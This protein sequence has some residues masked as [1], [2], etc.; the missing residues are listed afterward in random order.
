MTEDK[1]SPGELAGR[2]EAGRARPGA[3]RQVEP[4][5]FGETMNEKIDRNSP[6]R[7]AGLTIEDIPDD[8]AQMLDAEEECL[9]RTGDQSAESLHVAPPNVP[10]NPSIA[11]ESKIKV[12]P[13]AQYVTGEE[14]VDGTRMTRPRSSWGFTLVTLLRWV[15]M[16]PTSLVCGV[17]AFYL[18][19]IGNLLSMPSVGIPLEDFLARVFIELAS[20]AACFAVTIHLGCRI[21][22]SHK[23]CAACILA[24]VSLLIVGPAI[25][26]TFLQA[27]YWKLLRMTGGLL[28]VG[29]SLRSSFTRG[30]P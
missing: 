17:L 3:R 12:I 14:H 15:L 4:N 5:K 19:Q 10:A 20:G 24:G 11:P 16:I 2:S 29:I 6:Y 28:G 21:A 1:G 18:V 13:P 9:R 8:I 30:T 7:D 25:H 26:S 23:K 27:D 22:P